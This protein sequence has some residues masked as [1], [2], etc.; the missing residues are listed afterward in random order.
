MIIRIEIGT[1]SSYGYI[2][3]SDHSRLKLRYLKK[4]GYIREIGNH[5]PENNQFLN[6]N[7][8]LFKQETNLCNNK[9]HFIPSSPEFSFVLG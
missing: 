9:T 1:F 7:P 2:V 5:Y 3:K 4:I 6:K 8:N